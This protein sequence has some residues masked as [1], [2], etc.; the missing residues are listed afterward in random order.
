MPAQKLPQNTALLARLQGTGFAGM[1]PKKPSVVAGQRPASPGS[2]EET[3]A[4]GGPAA[5]PAQANPVQDLATASGS[6]APVVE[7]PLAADPDPLAPGTGPVVPF[8]PPLPASFPPLDQPTGAETG[9]EAGVGGQRAKGG[10]PGLADFSTV[11]KSMLGPLRLASFSVEKVIF[12]WVRTESAREDIPAADLWREALSTP[13][14]TEWWAAHF[15][16]D[17][18]PESYLRARH[19]PHGRERT[20][21]LIP[22]SL[23]DQLEETRQRLLDACGGFGPIKMAQLFEVLIVKW[24]LEELPNRE[25]KKAAQS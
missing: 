2:P 4:A 8:I 11:K 6:P 14:T 17:I 15:S 22:E 7:P 13:I 18:T 1:A 3:E 12:D 19:K 21:T 20:T 24:A 5:S 10:I 16:P 25:S 23:F 9:A